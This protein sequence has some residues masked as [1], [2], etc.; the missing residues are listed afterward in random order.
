MKLH[1]PR[2]RRLIA[3]LVAVAL[4]LAAGPVV[5]MHTAAAADA[6]PP[7][8]N[9]LAAGGFCSNA[10][11]TNPFN[12]LGGETASTRATI[13][14]LVATGLTTGTT[15]TTYTPAGTVTRRQMALFV[16]RAAD[17]FNE[18]ETGA[19]NLT[20]L[21]TYNGNSAYSDVEDNESGAIAIGRLT[22]AGVVGGFPDGTFRPNAPVSRRQ[23]A[24]F[25]NNLQKFMSGTALTTTKDFFT[26]DEGDTG[27]ANLN[28]LAAAGIFQGDGQG[29][30][31][32]GQPLTR[33]QMANILLRY[34]QVL[35]SAGIIESPFAPPSNATFD[36]TPRTL[37]TRELVTEPNGADDRLYEVTGLQAGTSYTIQLFPAANVQGT[38]TRTFTEAGATDTADDGTVSAD[39]TVV[40]GIAVGGGAD[41]NFVAQ[42]VNGAF[43]FT[44]D[45][46]AV[47][48][49]VPVVF[50]DADADGKVDLKADNTP[51]AT[52]P[53]GVGGATRYVPAEA[54]SGTGPFTVTAITA[55]R[56]AF[57]SGGLTYYMDAN[58]L[59][60]FNGSSI[61][62]A[63]FDSMLSVGD[64][65]TVTYNSDPAGV[66]T[67]NMTT[68]DVDAPA[69]PTIAVVDDGPGTNVDDAR[70]TYT[71]PAT[72]SP[73][74][75]YSLQRA[76]VDDGVDN[77]C[78]SIDDMAG[79]FA[80]VPSATQAAGTG[81]GVFV[82]SDDNVANG[83]YTYRIRATSPVSLNTADSAAPAAKPIPPAADTSA[84]I[85]TFAQRTT[86]AGT[87][88]FDSGDVVKIVFNEAMSTPAGGWFLRLT[89]G[90]GTVADMTA[91]NAT[92]A[93]N[94]A[95][96]V[97]NA[98]ARPA[99]TVLTITL[100]A[101]PTTYLA[102]AGTTAGLQA[103]A[104]VAD[105]SGVV[106]VSGNAWSLLLSS[107]VTVESA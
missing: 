52:E 66:S 38:T 10:P 42:P 20:S 79:T 41:D 47:E 94:G 92:A 76:T 4:G 15:S 93:L 83:C 33:R 43:A 91:T 77:T 26:D 78:G 56:D 59:Y 14:C 61:T 31:F 87:A 13:L 40:N 102:F 97:V 5:S 54:A 35:Q 60:R 9:P 25:V 18:H 99:G 104:T 21:P 17:L 23:M 75:T 68:D 80:N 74:V 58:D 65:G 70:I 27:E 8:A 81:S 7:I 72:N 29:H 101:P 1:P 19:F 53:F 44:I 11:T 39:V 95:P 100:S 34:A 2:T 36:V 86:N 45:G 49:V 71:R 48:T 73:G 107:D 69:A 16:M 50:R 63:Q 55:E 3:G 67:F 90:D 22:Q 88:A 84:P 30:V 46:S 96:E 24:A 32:P 28:A 6:L 37:L 62:K 82:F 103:P 51:V 12:D 57:T 64:A 85:S 89:D 98:V 105:R 106:D